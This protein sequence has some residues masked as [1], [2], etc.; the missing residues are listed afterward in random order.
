MAVL[1][2]TYPQVGMIDQILAGIWPGE[3]AERWTNDYDNRD[4]A[5]KGGLSTTLA[6]NNVLYMQNIDTF[7]RPASVA[8]ESNC[9]RQIKNISIAQNVDYNWHLNWERS[10]WT[11]IFIVEDITEVT[12]PTAKLKARDIGTVYDD[13]YALIDA[14]YAKG[15]IYQAEWSKSQARVTLRAGLTGFDIYCPIIP[16]GEGGIYNTTIAMDTS[17]AILLAGGE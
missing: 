7:Y 5:V 6:K 14:F 4:Q 12:D 17:I 16:S 2:S 15:W 8:P 1:H 13:V 11:G 3:K 10:K 9:W